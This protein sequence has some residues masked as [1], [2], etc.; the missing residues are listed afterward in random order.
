MTELT[1]QMLSRIPPLIYS[2]YCEPCRKEV[3]I[4]HQAIIKTIKLELTC[5]K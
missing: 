1:E 4:R 2:C 5:G 3:N